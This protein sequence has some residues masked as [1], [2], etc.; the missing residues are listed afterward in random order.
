MF[1]PHSDDE[2]DHGSQI[3]QCDWESIGSS[4]VTRAVPSPDEL[5]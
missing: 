3:N 4:I 1:V 2:D 5:L